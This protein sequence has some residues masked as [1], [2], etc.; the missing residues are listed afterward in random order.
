MA[1]AQ[2]KIPAKPPATRIRGTLSSLTLQNTN[3]SLN[4]IKAVGVVQTIPP[5]VD[6]AV[7]ERGNLAGGRRSKARVPITQHLPLLEEVS[8][9]H[10]TYLLHWVGEA[11][12][13]RC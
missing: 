11:Q 3:H 13:G 5:M 8:S 2:L 6:R 7:T 10:F 9:A 1:T 4:Q 12:T